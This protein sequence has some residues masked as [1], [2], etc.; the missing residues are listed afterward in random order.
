MTMDADVEG[1]VLAAPGRLRWKR[2][3]GQKLSDPDPI[4]DLWKGDHLIGGAG[5]A[6]GTIPMRKL[7]GYSWWADCP[8]LGIGVR[9]SPPRYFPTLAKAQEACEVYVRECL[10]DQGPT[11]WIGPVKASLIGLNGPGD[12][13]RPYAQ[14]TG[15]WR[16]EK[17]GREETPEGMLAVFTVRIGSRLLV[18]KMPVDAP[19]SRRVPAGGERGGAVAGSV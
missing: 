6:I 12:I 16:V 10:K 4:M 1:C 9:R 2:R 14:R 15:E 8:R 19:M 18:R 17:V 11:K 7:V 3:P 5:P 13:V